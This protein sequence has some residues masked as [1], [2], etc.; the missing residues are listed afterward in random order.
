MLDMRRRDFITLLGG[1]A[2]AWP[3]EGGAQQ[4]GRVYRIG[5]LATMPLASAADVVESF[6]NS[7]RERGYVEGQNLI[8]EFRSPTVSFEQNPEVAAELI[9]D[10]VDVILALGTPP[11]VAARRAMSTI[12]IVMI[13]VGDPVGSGLVAGLPRPGGNVT[14]LSNVASDLGGKMVDLLREI[15]PGIRRVGITRNFGN[16][17]SAELLRQIED[18]LRA[19]GLQFD[20]VDASTAAEFDHAFAYFG[21]NGANGVMLLPDSS[22]IQHATRI[23]ELAQ[24]AGLPTVFQHRESVVAGGLLSYGPN[25][26]DQAR[27]VAGHVDRILKG[28]QPA[29]LPVEQPTKFELVINLKTAK[30]FGLEMPPTLL[31]FADEVIE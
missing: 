16:P 25:L 17:G 28:V 18:A 24:R 15:V 10:G 4:A 30:A 11:V 7:L 27:Q 14:G 9:R 21:A 13:G 20:V 29:D 31:A 26:N 1:T 22:L 23:A 6:R 8:I 3:F 2:L 12:P 19:L 5:I